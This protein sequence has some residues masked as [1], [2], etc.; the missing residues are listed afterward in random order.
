MKIE[1]I[2]TGAIYSKYNSACTLINEDMIIDF[3]N[4]TLK[5]LLKNNHTPEKIDKIVITHMHGDHTAD[6]PFLMLYKYK[7]KKIE[8]D[9]YIIGPKGIEN[10]VKKLFEACNFYTGERMQK[11]IKFIELEENEILDK[12]ENTYKIQSF[13]VIHG[14]FSPTYGYI[15]DN[16]LGLTGDSAL[17]EGVEQIVKNSKVIIAD[18]SKIQ[19]DDAHMGIDNIISLMKEYNKIVIPTHMRDI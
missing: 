2:G 15:I 9:T 5:Q 4:G 7:E 1:L 3:P 10:C 16:K 14:K 12:V 11:H 6:I 18:C 17:C 8:E 13:P 19:G